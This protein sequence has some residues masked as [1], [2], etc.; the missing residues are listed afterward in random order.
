MGGA[1]WHPLVWLVGLLLLALYGP[2]VMLVSRRVRTSLHRLVESLLDLIQVE[3]VV[4]PFRP[5]C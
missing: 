2:A 4:K 5:I 1:D 3:H